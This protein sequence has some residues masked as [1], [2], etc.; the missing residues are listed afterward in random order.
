[1][2]KLSAGIAAGLIAIG[3]AAPG[4]AA[5]LGPHATDCR[6][7]A[8]KPAMLV[9]AEGLK[10]RVGTLRVQTY[11][12]PDH[13]FDKG[14]YA[15]RVD[16]EIPASG[17]VEV[18]MPVARSGVYAVAVTHRLGS[19]FQNGGGMS[20]NPNISMMD[21]LFKRR[22]E[23]GQVQVHVRGLTIVPVTMNY[24]RGASV[25]PIAGDER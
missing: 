20:G 23:P 7:G 4:A 6:P 8:G 16:V 5:I 3:A 15:E 24:V 12:D 18:C 22:P 25:G 11:D 2:S 10:S 17:P 13:Y 21:V 1:M 19:Q 14:A 9:K